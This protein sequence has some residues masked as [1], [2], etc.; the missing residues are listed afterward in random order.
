MK[1]A[2]TQAQEGQNQPAARKEG[3]GVIVESPQA[4]G[5]SGLSEAIN[6]SFP[7]TAQRKRIGRIADSP[8]ITVQR[9]SAE[10]L[11]VSPRMLG[12]GKQIE[13]ML[14]RAQ[15]IESAHPA[16]LQKNINP[17]NGVQLKVGGAGVM[18]LG[19]KEQ[20]AEAKAKLAMEKAEAARDLASV[21][22]DEAE[23]G[24]YKTAKQK[25]DVAE[26]AFQD[27]VA[28]KDAAKEQANIANTPTANRYKQSA[29]YAHD[30]TQSHC[31]RAGKAVTAKANAEA[32]ALMDQAVTGFKKLLDLI[33]TKMDGALNQAEACAQAGDA[34][35][36]GACAQ[37]AEKHK[38]AADKLFANVAKGKTS[39]NAAE[40]IAK[41]AESY[42]RGKVDDGKRVIAVYEASI[43][44][45]VAT[46]KEASEGADRVAK[47]KKAAEDAATA[48]L[49]AEQAAKKASAEHGEAVLDAA[50]ASEAYK[51]AVELALEKTKI[52]EEAALKAQASRKSFDVLHG[53]AKAWE[54]NLSKDFYKK[55][56]AMA[57]RGPEEVLS[58]ARQQAAD[59]KQ[60]ADKDDVSH[61]E[62]SAAK[63]EAE[64]SAKD[65]S[66]K[67]KAKDIIASDKASLKDTTALKSTDALKK[68]KQDEAEATKT[69]DEVADATLKAKM[70]I[71]SQREIR[72]LAGGEAEAQ[73]LL[74][75]V[76][77]IADL[78]TLLTVIRLH[79]P[80][81]GVDK[82]TGLINVK[83]AATIQ[84]LAGF[85]TAVANKGTLSETK[86][87]L[88]KALA[89]AGN[90]TI[91]D[92]QG[93]LAAAGTPTH[94]VKHLGELA[95]QVKG[96]GTII[97]TTALLTAV[98][99]NGTLDEI[100]VL[101][102]RANGLAGT[103]KVTELTALVTASGVVANV[104]K[105]LS[106]LLFCV[107]GKGTVPETTNL[108]LRVMAYY[109]GTI[110]LLTT[111]V[112]DAGGGNNVCVQLQVIVDAV[113]AHGTL[114]QTTAMVKQA[115]LT[116]G[117]DHICDLSPLIAHNAAN[118]TPPGSRH[119]SLP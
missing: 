85:V 101:M 50:T 68:Q 84:E 17:L 107:G 6:A 70:E 7:M 82:I 103:V 62:A 59:A 65:W 15:R 48:A 116:L 115:V 112:K 81:A 75:A 105:D 109:G 66:E 47:G 104:A 42:A 87:F 9:K 40:D 24:N 4:E 96:N 102:K 88:E 23:K 72:T 53:K 91:A 43:S 61:A 11:N 20:E 73:H 33:E 49:A 38:V 92:V 118:N 1:K 45:A 25:N 100:V 78:K 19:K 113:A 21:A 10:G 80:D 34:I 41:D 26:K 106:A 2:Q 86:T 97:E 98:G 60:V 90:P 54:E 79:Q 58:G 37:K 119:F 28:A 27:A 56:A 13:G 46:A 12:Q 16:F 36:S 3:A 111:L 39:V 8:A 31:I 69:K 114:Q 32:V 108:V 52:E 71:V 110:P 117:V 64:G 83:G 63:H 57:P 29:I 93:F 30:Q 5:L 76:P 89:L 95:D 35:T 18:Q 22:A 14:G 77:V 55:H 99:V 94:V 51:K 67:S 74:K 44:Q